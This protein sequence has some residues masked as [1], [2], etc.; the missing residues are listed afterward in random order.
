MK[1]NLNEPPSASVE[2]SEEPLGKAVPRSGDSGR[3]SA[4]D[5]GYL[6]RA[7][8]GSLRGCILYN[9]RPDLQC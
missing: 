5:V 4:L 9:L 3:S 8:S 2:E 6:H 1:E 7:G